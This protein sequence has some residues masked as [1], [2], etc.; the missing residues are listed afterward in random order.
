MGW[1]RRQGL[2]TRTSG[3][4]GRVYAIT[5]P[6][7]Q[8]DHPVIQGTFLLFCLWV[9][10]LFDS[11]ASHSFIA[12]SVVRELGLEVKTLEKPIGYI[13]VQHLYRVLSP[14]AHVLLSFCVE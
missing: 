10:I 13:K 12:A 7:E 8:E 4:Q 14:L 6:A 5:P 2:E 9:R 3:I 1:G 11:S